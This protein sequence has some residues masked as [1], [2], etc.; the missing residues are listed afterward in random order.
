MSGWWWPLAVDGVSRAHC[1]AETVEAGGV[2]QRATVWWMATETVAAC[3]WPR[4]VALLDD[5]ERQRAARMGIEANRRSYVAA[6]ALGRVLLSSWA[7]GAAQD[8]RFETGAHGKPEVVSPP[9]VPRLRLNLSHTRGLAAAALTVGHDIGVDVEWLERKST[10]LAVAR[11]F[12]AAEECAQ[13]EKVPPEAAHR[14]FLSLWTLKEA[15]VKAI[16]KGLAQPLDSFAF[17]LDPLTVRFDGTPADDPARWRFRRLQPTPGHLL[18]LAL[19]LAAP[20]EVTVET[21]ARTAAELG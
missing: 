4:L 20:G 18:A 15:Y 16:G 9:G 8:W 13:L 14:T 2:S 10:G 3:E 1:A 17:T 19:G 21:A 6:H 12:F 11:R 5:G 7:G